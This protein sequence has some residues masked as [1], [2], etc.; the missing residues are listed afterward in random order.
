MNHNFNEHTLTIA[1]NFAVNWQCYMGIFI[2]FASS[3]VVFPVLMFKLDFQLPI[4]IMFAYI[5]FI[6]NLADTVS[7][8]AFGCFK[9]LNLPSLHLLTLVKVGLIYVNY[10]SIDSQSIWLSSHVT[11][12]FIVFVQAFLGGYILMAYLEVSTNNFKSIFDRN[13]TGLL[14]SFFVQIGLTVGSLLSLLW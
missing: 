14:N 5:T 11:R 4:H 1:E 2:T 7:R 6:F 10:I 12:F 13:R 8:Y 9:I 3:L